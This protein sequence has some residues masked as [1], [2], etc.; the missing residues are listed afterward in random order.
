MNRQRYEKRVRED[1]Q[2]W[3]DRLIGKR[4]VTS[5][6]DIA[7]YDGWKS[8]DYLASWEPRAYYCHPNGNG[9][10][11]HIKYENQD[12]SPFL[13][14]PAEIRNIILEMVLPPEM[15]SQKT[16]VD[17][18][19]Q[20]DAVWMNTSA[21]IF[22]CKQLY[23]EGRTL[24]VEKHTFPYE[25]F[26]KK[27]RFCAAGNDERGYNWDLYVDLEIREMQGPLLLMCCRLNVV[28]D[29]RTNVI[30]QVFYR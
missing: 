2:T 29:T 5:D 21:I 7:A 19:E 26:A 17:G 25:K 14:L 12:S 4:I 24:A 22:T 13:R 3:R 9:F 6:P 23:V 11:K 30:K 28:C 20:G 15:L 27:T 18:M 10:D 1:A 16:D 8:D